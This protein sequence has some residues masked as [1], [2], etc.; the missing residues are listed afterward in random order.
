[1]SLE[2]KF[3]ANTGELLTAP[4]IWNCDTGPGRLPVNDG[5][6]QQWEKWAQEMMEK[7]V[8]LHGLLPNSTSVSAVMDELYRSFKISTR[9]E[10]VRVFA[11]KIYD[12]A[13]KIQK[14][15]LD[16]KTRIE[17]GEAVS[18]KEKE[19][20]KH[21][22]VATLN[23][24]DLGKIIF[25]TPVNGYPNP[26]SPFAK[27]FTKEK[28]LDAFDKL[29]YYPFTRK[30]LLN[31]K[32]RHE[33]GQKEVTTQIEMMN[34]LDAEYKQLREKCR[35]RGFKVDAFD[36]VLP[37]T[38]PLVRESTEH[39]RAKKLAKTGKT[40]SAGGIFRHLGSMV[41]NSEE[42]LLARMYQRQWRDEEREKRAEQK[43]EEHRKSYSAA[44]E[45]YHKHKRG[46]KLINLDLQVLLKYICNK[47]KLNKSDCSSNYKNATKMW[48]RLNNCKR[49]WTD[50]FGNTKDDGS[51]D[52]SDGENEIDVDEDIDID[53]ELAPVDDG[54]EGDGDGELEGES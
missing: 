44:L 12:L 13:K 52:V 51:G 50:Y 36:A 30:M 54:A 31:K 28:I 41:Y 8:I 47:E 26:D 29:G 38:T 1:M 46:D 14:Y 25:G 11:G 18:E 49:P 40:A 2:I 45:V 32:V 53:G 10:T 7:G 16:I 24:A 20:V 27:A 42:L 17:N 21:P 6:E 19:K 15:K 9:M 34:N 22:V 33:Q 39:E 37:T 48:E 3:D 43:S 35:E 23:P 4:V 5:E